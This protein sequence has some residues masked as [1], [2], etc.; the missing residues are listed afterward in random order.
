MFRSG[1]S[2]AAREYVGLGTINEHLTSDSA[3]RDGPHAAEDLDQSD[4]HQPMDGGCRLE[5]CPL[6]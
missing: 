3:P 2:P 4:Y 1:C 5:T 6:L